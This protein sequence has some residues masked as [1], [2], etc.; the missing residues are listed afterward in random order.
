MAAV[1]HKRSDVAEIYASTP[2]AAIRDD[3]MS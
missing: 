1:E 3:R 2:I